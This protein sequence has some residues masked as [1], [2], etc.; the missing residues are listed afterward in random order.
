MI[1]KT[2]IMRIYPLSLILLLSWGMAGCGQPGPLYLPDKAA[3]IHVEPDKNPE[4]DQEQT[5]EKDQEQT[6]EKDQ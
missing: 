4:K 3:P 5:Q 1:Y 6:Q 2:I